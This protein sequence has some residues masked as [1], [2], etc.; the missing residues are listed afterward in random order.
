MSGDMIGT[1]RSLY[2]L[3]EGI[4][5]SLDEMKK[6]F[7][8]YKYDILRKFFPETGIFEKGGKADIAVLD[9]IPITPLELNN[10]TSHLIFGVKGGKV[11]MTISY[12]NI[13]YK[14]GRITFLDENKIIEE[15]KRLTKEL[16]KR[17]YG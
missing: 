14:E 3:G 17:Y 9:Y 5:G 13:L 4:R 10:L 16:H 11:Y 1:L 6:I 8:D 7:F 2:L 12:G 15:S